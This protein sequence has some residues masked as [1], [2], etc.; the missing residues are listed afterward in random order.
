MFGVDIERQLAKNDPR[1]TRSGKACSQCFHHGD[2][3]ARKL[4]AAWTLAEPGFIRKM[5]K[6]RTM[7]G[8][9]GS[10]TLRFRDSVSPRDRIADPDGSSRYDCTE[11][12]IQR[13][14]MISILRLN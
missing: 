7:K 14:T 6:S 11:N 1:F 2:T 5:N 3:K 12:C 8:Q 4:V 9:A 13:R 10:I